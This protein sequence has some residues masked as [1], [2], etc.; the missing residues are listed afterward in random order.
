VKFLIDECLS[1]ELAQ[2]AR[3]RGHGESSH[4]I[5]MNLGGI[6]DWDLLP[7][8]LAGDWTLVTRNAY[9]F[10]GPPQAPGSSGQ[11]QRAEIHA[12]LVCLNG[13]DGMD[14]EMQRDL[15]AAVLDEIDRDGDLVNQVLE[16][17]LESADA[18]DI[19]LTRYPLPENPPT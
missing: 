13:P 7:I 5:W 15:F 11:Y 14:L 1:P 18:E 17:A 19:S 16:V 3:E 8:V 12:G 2:M 10:R 9:D 4:V 6:Q